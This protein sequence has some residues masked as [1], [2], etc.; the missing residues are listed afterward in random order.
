MA[1]RELNQRSK[2]HI[3]KSL[4]IRFSRKA[5]GEITR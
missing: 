1:M 2:N 4:K 3:S 5:E